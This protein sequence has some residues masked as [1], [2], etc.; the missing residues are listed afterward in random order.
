MVNIKVRLCNPFSLRHGDG[1][2]NDILQL[3]DIPPPRMGL[4]STQRLRSYPFDR[5][6]AD[7]ILC[8][9][10]SEE[11]MGKWFN[12]LPPFPQGRQ[13]NREHIET[14]VEVLPESPPVYIF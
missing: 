9:I 1:P 8:T 3:P 14:I 5:D 6:I 12:I 11:V 13:F 10:F 2:G 4:Q 7:A